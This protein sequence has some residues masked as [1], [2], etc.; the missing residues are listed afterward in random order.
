MGGDVAALG[1]PPLVSAPPRAAYL[2]D[3]TAVNIDD[4]LD[5]RAEKCT[6]YILTVYLMWPCLRINPVTFTLI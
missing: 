6:H 4:V 5:K 1:T 2:E 3:A